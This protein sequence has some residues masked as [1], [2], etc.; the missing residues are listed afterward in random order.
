GSPN[1]GGW[2]GAN[3]REPA[4]RDSEA[5]RPGRS[6]PFVDTHPCRSYSCPCTRP[7]TCALPA[8]PKSDRTWQDSDASSRPASV[9]RVPV[10]KHGEGHAHHPEI[11]ISEHSPQSRLTRTRRRQACHEPSLCRVVA[12]HFL[13][14]QNSDVDRQLY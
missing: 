9:H 12:F 3:K 14:F 13:Q 11:C 6:P 7:S 10:N 5:D 2:R 1:L 4:T 8:R